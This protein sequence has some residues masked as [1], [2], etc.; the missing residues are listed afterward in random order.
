MVVEQLLFNLSVI[1]VELD[2]NLV[3][4]I[5][6]QSP[7]VIRCNDCILTVSFRVYCRFSM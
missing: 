5:G 7:I 3:D 1:I 4:L 2:L 6:L